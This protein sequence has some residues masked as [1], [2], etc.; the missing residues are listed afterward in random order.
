MRHFPYFRQNRRSLNCSP[1]GGTYMYLGGNTHLIIIFSSK[2]EKFEF[3]ALCRYIYVLAGINGLSERNWDADNAELNK[4]SKNGK[5]TVYC[6]SP[7]HDLLISGRRCRRPALNVMSLSFIDEHMDKIK[8]QSTANA[9][10]STNIS[11]L[12]NLWYCILLL[13]SPAS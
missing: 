12:H 4:L 1:S 6:K 5:F 8:S 10:I 3:F 11:W 7:G 9:K 2:S 13:R